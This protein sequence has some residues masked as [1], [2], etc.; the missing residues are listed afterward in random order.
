MFES[1]INVGSLIVIIAAA[2]PAGGGCDPASGTTQMIST[3]K[4]VR[5]GH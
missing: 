1:L 2:F 3:H 5:A 4:N